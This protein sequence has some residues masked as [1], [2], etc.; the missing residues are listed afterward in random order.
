MPDRAPTS[1]WVKAL[2][3]LLVLAVIAAVTTAILLV[4]G[5]GRASHQL[6]TAL[7]PQPGRP[8]GYRGPSYP[9]MLTQDTVAGGAGTQLDIRSETPVRNE[10]LTAGNLVPTSSF[11][12]PTLCSPVTIANHSPAAVDSEIGRAHV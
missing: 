4:V 10:T 8:A 12:G 6:N 7:T 9:G 1:G 5:V 3:V 11:L 2:V